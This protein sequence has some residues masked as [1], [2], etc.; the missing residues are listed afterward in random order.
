MNGPGER[1]ARSLA[2]L[3]HA[4]IAALARQ[5]GIRARGPEIVVAAMRRAP[6]TEIMA[7]LEAAHS[8][9]LRHAAYRLRKRGRRVADSVRASA[10]ARLL[11]RV[12]RMFGVALLA[13]LLCAAPAAAQSANGAAADRLMTEAL[14]AWDSTDQEVADLA[15]LRAQEG[16][17]VEAIAKL[18]RIRCEHPATPVGREISLGGGLRGVT[19]EQV[20]A[21]LEKTRLA[22]KSIES[23][24]ALEKEQDRWLCHNFEICRPGE[25]RAA[26]P[27][28][29][30]R[31]CTDCPEMVVLP[32]GGLLMGAAPGEEELEGMECDDRGRSSPQ[33]RVRIARGFAIGRHEVTRGEYA[34]FARGTAEAL[35]P[36]CVVTSGDGMRAQAG[37]SW[38]DPGFVQDD[39]H[40]VVCVSWDDA[41]RYASWLALRTG[42]PYRLPTEAEWEYAARGGME[43]PRPWSGGRDASCEHANVLDRS[44]MRVLRD[45]VRGGAA[46]CD[47]GSSFTARVGSF[48]ANGFG[49][50]DMI[51]NAWEWVADCWSP[52]LAATAMPAG[53]SCAARSMRG[54]G[55]LTFP[56]D[57]RPAFRARYPAD[58]R[59]AHVGFRVARDM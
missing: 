11:A 33:V 56:R 58:E 21:R 2:A 39:S 3:R 37:R 24:D 59:A 23:L 52:S 19:R 48:R 12:G 7:D 18:A 54:G 28:Q 53:Q 43:W 16:R 44:G 17:I 42:K 26:S 13:L 29:A 45:L 27:R 50:H 9:F 41:R 57:A 49:L 34:A 46:A 38:R 14:A 55:W 25:A 20:I 22:I 36:S 31:D 5:R 4:G 8:G 32:P 47:D 10:I 30:L 1:L 35:P 51:G 6:V 40:P 15:G